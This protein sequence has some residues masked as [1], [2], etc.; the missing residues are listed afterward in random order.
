MPFSTLADRARGS[1][2]PALSAMRAPPHLA[3]RKE[4]RLLGHTQHTREHMHAHTLTHTREHM[5]VHT[6]ARL[7]PGT[8]KERVVSAVGG[9]PWP[10]QGGFP[11]HLPWRVPRPPLFASVHDAD[12][13]CPAELPAVVRAFSVRSA[14]L[15]PLSAQL[16]PHRTPATPAEVRAAPSPRPSHTPGQG[17]GQELGTTVWGP[18]PAVSTPLQYPADPKPASRAP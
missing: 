7:S 17:G 18:C 5:H 2:F 10:S 13:R 11:G 1:P 4:P 16:G 14:V 6:H 8:R 9:F 3:C 12:G 15:Q